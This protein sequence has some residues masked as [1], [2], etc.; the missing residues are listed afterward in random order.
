MKENDFHHFMSNVSWPGNDLPHGKAFLEMNDSQF[1][2]LFPLSLLLRRRRLPP[3]PSPVSSSSDSLIFDSLLCKSLLPE[4]V[5]MFNIFGFGDW[6]GLFDYIG[7]L[8]LLDCREIARSM[9]WCVNVKKFFI[10]FVLLMF[11]SRVGVLR[12]SMKF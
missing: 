5:D 9:L 11:H 3:A 4:V 8:W 2:N 7:C 12:G 6:I 1:P 10:F